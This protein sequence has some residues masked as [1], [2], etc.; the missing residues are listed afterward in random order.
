M[1]N[2]LYIALGV[3]FVYSVLTTIASCSM[4]KRLRELRPEGKLYLSKDEGFYCEFHI[5]E[6]AIAKK[7]AITL[8]VVD[9]DR[10]NKHG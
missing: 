3:L 5:E 2:W 4:R 9:T 6:E 8:Q 1:E 7:E 10:R